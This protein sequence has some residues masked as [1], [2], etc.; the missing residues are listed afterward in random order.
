MYQ[1]FTSKVA[2]GRKLPKEKVLEVAKGR[3]WTGEDAKARGLVDELGGYP[4]ALKLV[5]QAIKL[6]ESDDVTLRVFPKKK[7]T[8]EAIMAR[9]NNQDESES[10]EAKQAELMLRVLDEVRPALKALRTMQG[11][12]AQVLSMPHLNVRP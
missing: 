10:S 12:D 1:D 11:G 3:I 4:I 8:L 2:D 9:L 7:T 5:K 6:K